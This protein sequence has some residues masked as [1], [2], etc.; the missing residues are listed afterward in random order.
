MLVGAFSLQSL[1]NKVSCQL[2]YPPTCSRVRSRRSTPGHSRPM[3]A[4]SY[5]SLGSARN[6]L[7]EDLVLAIGNR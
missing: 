6:L 3:S 2:Y 7:D 4:N 5:N 1:Q